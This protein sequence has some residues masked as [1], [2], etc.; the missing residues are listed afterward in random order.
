MVPDLL[1]II[2]DFLPFEDLG[3]FAAVSKSTKLAA[4]ESYIRRPQSD[5][6]DVD[7]MVLMDVMMDVGPAPGE[8][9]RFP[10]LTGDMDESDMD[11]DSDMESDPE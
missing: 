7:L 10:N 3:A 5:A 9:K 11:E 4:D 2:T 6:G 8:R 1:Q